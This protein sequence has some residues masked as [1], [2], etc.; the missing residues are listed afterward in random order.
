VHRR[1]PDEHHHP[2]DSNTDAHRDSNAEGHRVTDADDRR[3]F[4]VIGHI[5]GT[6]ADTLR[7]PHG[8]RFRAGRHGSSGRRML[9]FGHDQGVVDYCRQPGGARD[10]LRHRVRLVVLQRGR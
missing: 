7:L 3:D 4:H 6:V 8:H 2:H 5:A 1:S 10:L 9:R